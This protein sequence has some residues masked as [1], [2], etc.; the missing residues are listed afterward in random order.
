MAPK[1]IKLTKA[2]PAHTDEWTSPIVVNAASIETVR[3]FEF[4]PYGSSK[5]RSYV[6]LKNKDCEAFWVAEP[7]EDIFALLQGDE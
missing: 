6:Q 5:A 1:F 4:Y 2:G 7:V 3:P